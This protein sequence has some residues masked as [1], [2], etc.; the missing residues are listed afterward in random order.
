MTKGHKENRMAEVDQAKL[1]QD[2]A[3][4]MSDMMNIGANREARKAFIDAMN[5]EHRYLQGMF[6]RFCF[7]WF[8]NQSKKQPNEYD[9]RN[10]CGVIMGKAL[11]DA[12]Y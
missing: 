1:G 7:E 3:R 6:S 4:Q 10:Q 9:Q 12:L 5:K 8:E 2:L 11:M